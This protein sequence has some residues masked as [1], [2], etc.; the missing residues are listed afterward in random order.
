VLGEQGELD[1]VAVGGLAFLAGLE[2]PSVH[3]TIKMV[4]GSA[5]TH[6]RRSIGIRLMRGNTPS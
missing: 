3:P 2:L 4:A 1:G 6:R 5:A